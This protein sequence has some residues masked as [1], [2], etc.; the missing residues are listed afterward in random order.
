MLIYG[1]LII[2]VVYLPIFALSGVEGKMFHPMAFTVVIALVGAMISLRNIHPGGNCAR[3]LRQGSGK[4]KVGSSV[5]E[6]DVCAGPRGGDAQQ[7]AHVTLAVVIVVLSG[8]LT[9]RMGSEF[10]PSLMRD[11]ALHAIRIPGRA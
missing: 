6:E 10:I 7:G 2:M 11:I 9:T 3:P 5:G 1:E 8:L 4:K